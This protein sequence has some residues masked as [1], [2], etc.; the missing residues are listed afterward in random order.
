MMISGNPPDC[1]KCGYTLPIPENYQF[2]DI[3]NR[4][5][6][7][8]R[9]EM[10]SFNISALKFISDIEGIDLEEFIEKIRIY[11]GHGM[12]YRKKEDNKVNL[13]INFKGIN[14]DKK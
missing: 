12:S 6:F 2:I 3:V 5:S 7:L 10:G 8:I 14:K 1:T 4:Y 11:Y 13:D 9:D